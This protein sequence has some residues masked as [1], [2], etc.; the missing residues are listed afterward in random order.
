MNLTAKQLADKNAPLFIKMLKEVNSTHD[1]FIRTTEERHKIACI[2]I[3]NRMS[4]N[5]DI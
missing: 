1:D 2:E 4:Q 3:W 5:D